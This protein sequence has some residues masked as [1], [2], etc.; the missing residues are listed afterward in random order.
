MF[1]LQQS[2]IF[3]YMKYKCYEACSLTHWQGGAQIVQHHSLERF[4]E[5]I[6]NYL[7]WIGPIFL[8]RGIV[9]ST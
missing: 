4:C 2:L 5:F 6:V 7:Q 3:F 1:H 8:L 9:I